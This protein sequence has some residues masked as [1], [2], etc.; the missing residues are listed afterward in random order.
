MDSM[1]GWFNNRVRRK[2]Q[3]IGGILTNLRC[4]CDCSEVDEYVRQTEAFTTSAWSETERA[5]LNAALGRQ[6][7]LNWPVTPSAASLAALRELLEARQP[8]RRHAWTLTVPGFTTGYARYRK[9]DSFVGRIGV[10]FGIPFDHMRRWATTVGLYETFL[11]SEDYSIFL[12]GVR[13]GISWTY[14]G[15]SHHSLRLGIFGEFGGAAS[16]QPVGSSRRWQGDVYSQAGL[17]IGYTPSA[18]AIGRPHYGVDILGG[19]TFGLGGATANPWFG[20]GVQFGLEFF[21]GGRD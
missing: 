4:V 11:L 7:G 12:S 13:A 15:G 8:G 14:P 21:G 2:G 20:I 1:D 16:R 10:D 19:T 18:D 17:T 6:P 9:T 5:Y 3:S